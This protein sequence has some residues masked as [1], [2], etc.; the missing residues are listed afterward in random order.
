MFNCNNDVN[1][2]IRKK[3]PDMKKQRPQKSLNPIFSTPRE[4]N[5]IGEYSPPWNDA[6][7]IKGTQNSKIHKVDDLADI[8]CNVSKV[9][10][11]TL[12]LNNA[13]DPFHRYDRGITFEDHSNRSSKDIDVFQQ[14]SKPFQ[15]STHN[16]M[17]SAEDSLYT[18][19]FET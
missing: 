8:V 12:K 10:T 2:H 18:A 16:L 4:D 1:I 9:Q 15:S 17:K 14:E 11:N 5:F 13:N 3:T 6:E 19:H 7:V